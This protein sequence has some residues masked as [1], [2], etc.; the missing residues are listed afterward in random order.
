M[1]L[2]E[3]IRMHPSY[4]DQAVRGPGET[5]PGPCERISAYV[6]ATIVS[7]TVLDAGELICTAG[8]ALN[9]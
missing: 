2:L 3:T 7:V 5:I 9:R 6:P 8:V 1:D 4:P